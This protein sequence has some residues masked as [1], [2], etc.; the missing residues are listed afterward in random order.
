MSNNVYTTVGDFIISGEFLDNHTMSELEQHIWGELEQ[1]Q[2]TLNE[3]YSCRDSPNS[4]TQGD[5]EASK[6][7]VRVV[8]ESA[9]KR[10][11]IDYD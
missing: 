10:F 8:L 6:L 5:M 4:I 11:D 2:N 7:R 3:N 9:S 1:L